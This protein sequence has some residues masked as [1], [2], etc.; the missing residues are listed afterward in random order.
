[1]V[2]RKKKTLSARASRAGS[3]KAEGAQVAPIGEPL[4][5]VPTRAPGNTVA[6]ALAISAPVARMSLNR[7][8]QHGPEL[9]RAASRIETTLAEQKHAAGQ[10]PRASTRSRRAG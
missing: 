9:R 7:A 2:T 1:M 8:L 3:S 5:A 10:A 4:S 6:A